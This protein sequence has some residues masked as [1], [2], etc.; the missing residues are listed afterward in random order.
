MPEIGTFN[1]YLQ[2]KFKRNAYRAPL[3]VIYSLNMLILYEI[4]TLAGGECGRI[5]YR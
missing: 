1:K 5:V 2:L 4:F 3:R